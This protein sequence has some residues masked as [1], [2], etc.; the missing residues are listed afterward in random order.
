[1]KEFWT[2]EI[3]TLRISKRGKLAMSSQFSTRLASLLIV[4]LKTLFRKLN[5]KRQQNN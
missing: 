3:V 4:T 2:F 1:L 5:R